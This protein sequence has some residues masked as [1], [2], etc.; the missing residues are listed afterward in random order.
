M[1]LPNTFTSIELGSL[2]L[3]AIGAA[4]TASGSISIASIFQSDR[5]LFEDHLPSTIDT[6]L[7]FENIEDISL[8]S[9]LE[10]NEDAS[11][12]MTL[13]SEPEF[14]RGDSNNSLRIEAELE[15]FADTS[16]A[17]RLVLKREFDLVQTASAWIYIPIAEDSI[18]NKIS[19]NLILSLGKTDEDDEGVFVF[20]QARTI[21]AGEWTNVS[22]GRFGA[23]SNST[24]NWEGHIQHL[25]INIWS[26]E[27]YN[28]PIYLDDIAILVEP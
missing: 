27:D 17:I 10:L 3:F 5:L 4:A 2:V 15:S 8:I 20:S 12:A 22:V 24:W 6:L 18:N 21:T 14:A 26:S 19:V 1:L 25:S 23:V 13:S 11:T 16:K 7:D 9:D 28:G